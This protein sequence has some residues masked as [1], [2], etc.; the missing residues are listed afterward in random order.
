MLRAIRQNLAQLGWVDA[1]F[2]LL[3]QL[4]GAVSGRRIAIFKYYFVAQ[5]V[6]PRR[7]LSPSR[8]KSI[9]VRQIFRDDPVAAAF[10]RPASVVR[11]RYCQDALCL[12][13]LQ[14]RKFIGFLWLRLG[15]YQEDEVRARFIPSP[16]GRAAWDFDVHVEPGHRFGPALLRLWDEANELLRG[17]GVE[18][19]LSRISAF[20]SA[21]L[22]AHTRLGAR[23]VA[24]AT[25]LC[26][27]QWQLMIATVKPYVHLSLNAKSFPV[28]RLDADA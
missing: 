26:V 15:P 11:N 2:Y 24:S 21:S 17:N 12:A 28:L 13:A 3:K 18:W 14:E 22:V 1:V 9:E 20:N 25:F 19:S 23:R 7:L 27:G 8:G 10:P 4:L 6:A 5:P 16:V